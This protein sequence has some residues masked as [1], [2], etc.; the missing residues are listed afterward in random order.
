LARRRSIRLADDFEKRR[1]EIDADALESAPRER[2]QGSTGAA[3]QIDQHAGPREAID[4]QFLIEIEQRVGGEL[5]VVVAGNVRPMGVFPD[6]A[7]HAVG[8]TPGR[9]RCR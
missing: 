5:V 8:Q 6:P 4:Q 9:R 7:R 3:T 1:R 2:H